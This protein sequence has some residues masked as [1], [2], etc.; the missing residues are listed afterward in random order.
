MKKLKTISEQV[1]DYVIELI[2][3]KQLSPGEKITEQDLLQQLD[4]SRTPIREALK[5]LT[6]DGVLVNYPRKGFFVKEFNKET[7]ILD[8]CIMSKL[9]S[10]AAELAV[11]YLTEEDFAKMQE[12]I[13]NIDTALRAEPFDSYTI[14]LYQTHQSD[15][16]SIYRKRCPNYRLV[17]LIDSILAGAGRAAPLYS[18]EPATIA[19]MRECNNDHRKILQAF[20]DKDLETLNQLI[21]AHWLITF[22]D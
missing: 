17:D 14:Q 4:T 5:Q 8:Y 9:D 21:S 3:T 16:H 18:T 6:S 13:D 20:K 7:S 19:T 22:D 1:Y 11:D 12:C 15:F 2:S 10:Y